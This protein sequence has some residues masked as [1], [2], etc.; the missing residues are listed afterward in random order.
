MKNTRSLSNFLALILGVLGTNCAYA[1]E[2]EL[3]IPEFSAVDFNIL[4]FNL[5][6]EAILLAGIGVALL[7]M[8]F[9]L[10]EFL[11]TKRLPAHKSMLDISSL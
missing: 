2:V 11:R 3:H 6:G 10:Y 8:V 5:A 1:S 7:G 9:G 4:G